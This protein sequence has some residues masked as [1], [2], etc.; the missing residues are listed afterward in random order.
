M[1]Y[2]AAAVAPPCFLTVRSMASRP[3]QGPKS[4]NEFTRNRSGRSPDQNSNT[5]TTSTTGFGNKKREP[6]WQCVQ[7]CGACC[8]LDKGPTFPSPEE[9]F[10]DPSDVQYYNSLIG[11]DGW[12]IH[13]DKA[14]RKC[15]IYADRPYFCRVEPDIFQ[16][17]YGIDKKK[18]NMEACSSCIDT[19]KAIHGS[20]SKELDD[21]N[22][23]IWN[24]SSKL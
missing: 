11:T 21:F 5:S 12:C 9:I 4:K 7:N 20:N 3:R 6:Q 14:T 13:F 24:A 2:A 19:I 23:A 8:K 22:H 10:E 18:F 15:S 16:T 17:L 1:A